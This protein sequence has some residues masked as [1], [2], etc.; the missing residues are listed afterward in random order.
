MAEQ[1]AVVLLIDCFTEN[2]SVLRALFVL[3]T[4]TGTSGEAG[5]DKKRDSRC[6]T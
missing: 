6:Q 1:H 5:A 3:G 2:P 4:T